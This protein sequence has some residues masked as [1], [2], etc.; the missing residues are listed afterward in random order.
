MSNTV[1][2]DGYT[3]P[4]EVPEEDMQKRDSELTALVA[5]YY[6]KER[7]YLFTTSGPDESRYRKFFLNTVAIQME[8]TR[9]RVYVYDGRLRGAYVV[10]E[11]PEIEV[12]FDALVKHHQLADRRKRYCLMDDLATS[13][14]ADLSEETE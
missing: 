11:S 7:P 8:M 14:R 4:D 1:S 2:T 3:P 9:G 6:C 10:L 12:A 13:L 5:D